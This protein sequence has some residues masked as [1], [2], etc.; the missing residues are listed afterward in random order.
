M[1]KLRLVTYLLM[2]AAILG[3][4]LAGCASPAAAPATSNPP[5]QE[6]VQ[7][8]QEAEQPANGYKIG[9]VY[10]TLNNPFFVDQ[11]DGAD[12]AGQE[13]GATISHVS[14]DNDVNKQTKLVE[15]FIAQGVDAIVLQAVDTKGIVGAIKEANDAGIPVFTPGET[16]AGGDVVT[17]AVFNEVDT[18]KTAAKFLA[19][20]VNPG[21]KVVMLLGIQGTETA[22]NRQ[23]GFETQLKEDCPDCEIVA[24]QPADFDRSKGLT[25]MEAILQAQ[26]QIDAVWAANDEMALGAIKAIQEAGRQDEMFVVGTDGIGDAITAIKDGDLAATYALPAFRQGYMTVETAIKY[27]EGV[28]VCSKITEQGSMITADNVQQ[29]EK[30]MKAVDPADRYWESCYP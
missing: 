24:K 9:F 17:S 11:Q 27:L 30:I 25:V 29:A 7:P 22:Q 8:S 10:P 16:P 15:D 13:F 14:G 19:S 5:T 28:Q 4:M 21:A 18:G 2:L 3:A 6:A 23:E 1:N 20:K 12:A 26:P